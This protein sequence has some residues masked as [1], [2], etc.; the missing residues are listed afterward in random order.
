MITVGARIGG[1]RSLR[2]KITVILH[3]RA[4]Y[5]KGVLTPLEPLEL[6]EGAEVDVS[7]DRASRPPESRDAIL[8]ASG[9]WSDLGDWD[10][11]KRII[12]EARLTGSRPW[13][14]R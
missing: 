3:V 12:Y 8:A 1:S 2:G 4:R 10:A 14:D 5:S 7:L 9:G 13:P 11:F 6:E